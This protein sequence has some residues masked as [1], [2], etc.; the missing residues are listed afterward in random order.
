MHGPQFIGKHLFISVGLKSVSWVSPELILRSVC[1]GD[2]KIRGCNVELTQFRECEIYS[3]F[4]CCLVSRKSHYMFLKY[5]TQFSLIL[6]WSNSHPKYAWCWRQ[7]V[8]AL[9]CQLTQLTWTTIKLLQSMN[10]SVSSSRV[11]QL[12]LPKLCGC[13]QPQRAVPSAMPGRQRRRPALPQPSRQRR[14]PPPAPPAALAGRWRLSREVAARLPVAMAAGDERGRWEPRAGTGRD[15]RRHR[16]TACCSPALPAPQPEPQPDLA[17]HWLL[18][19]VP[20]ASPVATPLCAVAQPPPARPG[21]SGVRAGPGRA[22]V[23]ARVPAPAPAGPWARGPSA[24]H[25]RGREGE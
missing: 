11:S 6:R 25:A 16:S 18:D 20:G 13:R 7:H 22:R 23:P 2:R 21:R 12:A 9:A 3:N 1:T 14:R 15:W 8:L 24:L 17:V 5:L 10:V 19:R 4:T